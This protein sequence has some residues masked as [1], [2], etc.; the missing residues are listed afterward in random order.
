MNKQTI[1]S[2]QHW[3]NKH[4]EFNN[5]EQTNNWKPAMLNKQ[6]IRIQQHWT[7]K[8]SEVSNA[9][10]TNNQKSATLNKQTIRIQQHWTS[11]QST[12]RKTEQVNDHKWN[13][14]YLRQAIVLTNITVSIPTCSSFGVLWS[15]CSP[16]WK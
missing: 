4:S 1:G 6:T 11:K 12:V 13:N 3:T 15:R 16:A 10:Q 8:Q 9:E 14:F 7:S 5:A 2:Q